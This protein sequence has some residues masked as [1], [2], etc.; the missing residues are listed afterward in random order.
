MNKLFAILGIMLMVLVISGCTSL[1]GA[2]NNSS[3]ANSSGIN[4][5]TDLNTAFQQAQIS[6]KMV[7]VDFYADW[8]HYC[9][10]MD[11]ETYTDVN[12]QQRIAQSYI[13]VK[14]N[15]DDHP[16]LSSQ[17]GIYGLPTIIIFDSNGQEIK[18]IEGYQSSSQLLSQL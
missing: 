6:N 2:Q 15:T 8:C 10:Q 12:V 5:N 4:W 13:A 9:N 1:P 14:I 16:D 3:S 18:R 11:S 7:F 17:Y